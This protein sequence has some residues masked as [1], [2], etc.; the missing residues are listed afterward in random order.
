MGRTPG[1]STVHMIFSIYSFFNNLW[2]IFVNLFPHPVRI[3]FLRLIMKKMGK[4][5]FIDHWCFFRYGSRIYIGDNV[6]I[7]RNCSI[8]GSYYDK[9][10]K[11]VIGDNVAIAPEVKFFAPSH[12]YQTLDLPDYGE[13]IYIGDH[14]W[15]GGGA[16]ILP[17]VTIG[18][19]AIIG[20]GSV[21]TKDI[22]AWSIAVGNPAKVIKKRVIEEEN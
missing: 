19:G 7:N 6:A 13:S 5:V 4:N 1:K 20:A 21:V 2:F 17:G 3:L 12:K 11:I 18:E 14:V 15:I 16:I 22:P 10:T 8:Y 9:D